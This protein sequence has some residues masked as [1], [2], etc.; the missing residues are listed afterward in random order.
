MDLKSSFPVNFLPP[1]HLTLQLADTPGELGV[2]RLRQLGVETLAE[3]PPTNL[4]VFTLKENRTEAV[5]QS[6]A[7]R[8]S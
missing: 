1:G 8:W 3:A 2:G 5:N 7:T 6:A 4:L